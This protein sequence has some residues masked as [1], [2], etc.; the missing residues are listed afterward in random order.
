M[1]VHVIVWAKEFYKLLF[2]PKVEESMLFEDQNGDEKSTFMDI[3]LQLR[4]ELAAAN[5]IKIREKARQLLIA[6][7]NTEI[8]KQL[9]MD[10]FK[11]AKKVPSPIPI[12]SFTNKSADQDTIAP[13]KRSGYKHTDIWSQDDCIAE[14][15]SCIMEAA[16][17]LREG[18]NLLP[19]FDK[20]DDL[21]MR[22]VTCTSN[23]RSYVFGIEPIQSHYSAKGIAGNIIPAIATT[24]AI[25]AG[26]QVLQAFQVLAKQMENKPGELKECCRF[27]Y[28]LRDKTRQGYYL[29]P[30]SLPSPNPK[31][32]VCRSAVLQLT[33]DTTKWTFET[34]LRRIVKKELGFT[35]PSINIGSSMIYE[36]GDDIDDDEYAAIVTKTLID[37]PAG[38]MKD[39][40]IITIEDFTQDLEVDVCINHKSEWEKKEA[41]DEVADED[42]FIIGGDKPIVGKGEEAKDQPKNDEK[43]NDD[44]IVILDDE[45]SGDSAQSKKREMSDYEDDIIEVVEG[46]ATKKVRL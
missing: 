46:P 25:V 9:D 28:C 24:N 4:D 12:D 32:F 1:P 43:E 22:F 11:T 27:I 6:L 29:Q 26:L 21:A 23:L 41:D 44:D 35:E 39:G 45:N 14:T 31:C 3:V 19:E 16:E 38:G 20:D 33:L 30:T 18:G 37:L 13:S 2:N 34:L 17:T 42:R 10:R 40:T 15:M 36:E 5:D 7:Y 8:Q